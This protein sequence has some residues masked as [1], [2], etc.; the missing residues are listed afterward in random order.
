MYKM[1]KEDAKKHL[2]KLRIE[3]LYREWAILKEV[4]SSTPNDQDLGKKI[5]EYFNNKK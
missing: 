2:M 4:V 3:A 5:R 1:E